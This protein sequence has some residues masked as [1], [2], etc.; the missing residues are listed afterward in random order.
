[1]SARKF[2]SD[3]HRNAEKSTNTSLM[4]DQGAAAGGRGGAF[5]NMLLSPRAAQAEE[6]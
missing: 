1:M 4:S 2:F 3:D 6:L 5:D